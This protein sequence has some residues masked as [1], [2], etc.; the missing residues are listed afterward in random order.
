MKIRS[1][2][3]VGDAAIEDFSAYLD[4]QPFA[5]AEQ[6]EALWGGYFPSWLEAVDQGSATANH[7][8]AWLVLKQKDPNLKFDAVSA[9]ARRSLQKP[10]LAY[11]PNC[12]KETGVT[13]L[14]K[15]DGTREL[16][17]LECQRLHEDDDGEDEPRPTTSP[18]RKKASG[19]GD[20]ASPASPPI[21]SEASGSE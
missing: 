16:R 9:T 7:I 8:L 4:S 19:T 13:R 20:D 21:S 17:C 18:A 10:I 14:D 15:P 11:C 1:R 2:V 3:S 6:I 12:G 5:E